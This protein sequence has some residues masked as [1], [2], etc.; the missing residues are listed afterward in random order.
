[1][2]LKRKGINPSCIEK[3]HEYRNINEVNIITEIINKKMKQYNI[4]DVTNRKKL[5]DYLY[6]RGFELNYIHEALKNFT[7]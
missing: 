5:M 1:M 2:E 7:D 4:N 3:T 6:R